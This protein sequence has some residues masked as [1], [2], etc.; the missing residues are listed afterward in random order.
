MSGSNAIFEIEFDEPKTSVCDCCGKKTVSLTRFVYKD[1]D[2][3]AIYYAA[4][5][6]GHPERYVQTTMCLG[7]WDETADPESRVTFTF[8]ICG[9]DDGFEVGVVD[10]ER[11]LWFGHSSLFGPFLSRE[12]ALSHPWIDIVFQISDAICDA[13]E[14]IR[15]FLASATARTN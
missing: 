14:P 2:A 10:G 9:T 3:F 4:F 11:S 12:E 15:A 1:G 5:A 8:D 13:D 6:E 7:D